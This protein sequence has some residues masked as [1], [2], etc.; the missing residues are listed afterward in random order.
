MEI[1]IK[2]KQYGLKFLSCRLVE[3]QTNLANC[4][5]LKEGHEVEKLQVD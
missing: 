4:M 5:E 2:E 3:E 1:E